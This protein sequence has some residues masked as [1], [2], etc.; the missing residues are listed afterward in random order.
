MQR[1]G[2]DYL[3]TLED[4]IKM[5]EAAQLFQCDDSVESGFS[6]ALNSAQLLK[7]TSLPS[8]V[9]GSGNSALSGKY[10]GFISALKLD[11]GLANLELYSQRVV[12]FCADYGTEAKFMEVA[13]AAILGLR[14][15]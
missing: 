11:A 13:R 3:M 15:W 12:S 7:T 2:Q 14:R 5:I 4:S 8:S 6:N 1:G 10:E 9:V